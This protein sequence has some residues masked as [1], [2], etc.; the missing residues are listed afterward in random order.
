MCQLLLSLHPP[1]TIKSASVPAPSPAPPPPAIT[2]R[3]SLRNTTDTIKARTVIETGIDWDSEV[4]GISQWGRP[5]VRPWGAKGEAVGGPRG[6]RGGQ[7]EA[8][9]GQ[10]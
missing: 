2:T 9:G 3:V 7:G 5:R 4:S 1:T 6:G 10:D 8:V